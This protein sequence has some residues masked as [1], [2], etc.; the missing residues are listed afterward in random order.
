VIVDKS[1]SYCVVSQYIS[2][3][4]VSLKHVGAKRVELEINDNGNLTINADEGSAEFELGVFGPENLPRFDESELKNSVELRCEDFRKLIRRTMFAASTSFPAEIIF[5]E[6]MMMCTCISSV[7]IVTDRLKIETDIEADIR[8]GSESLDLLGRLASSKTGRMLFSWSEDAVTIQCDDFVLTAPMV[9]MPV[10]NYMAM[11]TALQKNSKC[12]TVSILEL[13]RK[14]AP[15]LGF[16]GAGATT[17]VFNISANK[18][19]AELDNVKVGRTKLVIDCNYAGED[20]VIKFNIK[21][22]YG[23]LRNLFDGILTI[24][25]EGSTKPVL[26]INDD[27]TITYILAPVWAP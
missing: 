11:I 18:I 8:L 2:E 3:A 16:M 7:K 25:I 6:N 5:K 14:L 27:K 23:F 26:F 22:L 17:V 9:T 12:I 19:Q 21:F 20:F 4:I 24:K 15:I 10:P 1:G 13:K